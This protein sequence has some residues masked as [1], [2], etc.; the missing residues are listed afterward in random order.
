MTIRKI[1]HAADIHLDSPLQKLGKYQDAPAEQ[2][3][4]ASRRAL[5]NLT[6]LAIDEEV[7]LVLVAGD[8]YDGDWRDQNTGLYFV[9]QASKLIQA[10]IPIV[11]IRGNHDAMNVMT[12]SLPLPKNP[13]GSD[14]MMAA[15]RVDCRLFESLGIAVHGR[16]FGRREEKEGLAQQYPQ[17]YSGMFNIGL[18][19]TSLNGM[20]AHDRYAPCTPS[21]LTDKEYDYWALG[22]IHARGDHGISGGSPIVFSGN[23]QGRH[24]RE[25]GEKGCMLL[26]IDSRDR[27]N[28]EFREL[29]VVRWQLCELDVSDVSRVEDVVEHFHI[30]VQ[31]MLRQIGDRLLVTR[32]QLVGETSLHNRF[33][34]SVNQIEA[35]LRS[36]SISHGQERTWIEKVAVKTQL[37]VDSSFE[38]LDGPLASVNS[39]IA[40]L[41]SFNSGSDQ[42]LS[43]TVHNELGSLLRKLPAE[44]VGTGRAFDLED[45]AWL[46][47]MVTSA[48]ADVL[49]RLS[50]SESNSEADE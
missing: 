1:L 8:L 45:E 28:Y 16:S 23:I 24:I 42:E 2:I 49:N 10:G 25:P 27:V 14:V 37:P 41:N 34:G 6:Q 5:Q 31:Q 46:R 7:D 12:S 13:D 26:R 18:L 30:W 3:R 36:L 50:R 44:L 33:H 32:V 21:Q 38:D 47:E 48:S 20:G 29:D 43:E 11:V 9:S 19:H 4:G 39:V 22:H 15:D 40:E 35:D 17:P